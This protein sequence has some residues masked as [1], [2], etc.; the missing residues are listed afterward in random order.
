VSAKKHI[1]EKFSFELICAGIYKIVDDQSFR[2]KCLKFIKKEFIFANDDSEDVKCLRTIVEIVQKT[3]QMGRN[4][5]ISVRNL[6]ERINTLVELDVGYKEKVLELWA[7]IG[8]TA[9]IY[10]KARDEASMNEFLEYLQILQV[11]EFGPGFLTA[12]KHNRMGEVSNLIGDLMAKVSEIVRK[13]E[14]SALDPEKIKEILPKNTR[15]KVFT[16]GC[17]PIDADLG[18][19]LPQTLNLVIAVTGNGK[20]MF[21]HHII[22]KAIENKMPVFVAVVEDNEEQ[23]VR[24]LVACLTGIRIKRLEEFDKLNLIEMGDVDKAIEN[25]KK[26]VHVE[27]AYNCDVNM[28]HKLANNYD[29]EC[30]RLNKAVPI[31]NILDYT[32]HIAQFSAGDKGFEKMRNAYAA[33]KNYALANNKICF[34]FAQ[35]NREGSKYIEDGT[36]V[37]TYNDLAGGFDI[38]QVCD[39]IMTIN[40][41]PDDRAERK[42]RF[43]VC[44]AR[45][46]RTGAIV[47]V[48]TNYSS[49]R[50]NMSNCERLTNAPDEATS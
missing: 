26:Y 33:R 32:G 9:E 18:G 41:S 14:I 23:F 31:I 2:D 42:A 6:P 20:S 16:I 27:F 1:S 22:S 13:N 12:Y 19:F 3:V 8:N 5:L 45:A 28:I 48:E 24:K 47:R 15:T 35:V 11:A 29:A 40:R 38:A 46:G 44:K 10:G 30:R 49:A 4:D 37:L 34:D 21:A 17:D 7:R 36:G 50:F 39:T 25:I 43:H